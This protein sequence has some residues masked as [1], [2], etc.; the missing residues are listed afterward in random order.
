MSDQ[1]I[2]ENLEIRIKNTEQQICTLSLELA[3]LRK[4]RN[5]AHFPNPDNKCIDN[6][7][8]DTLNG[9]VFLQDL[10]GSRD[11]LLII[12]NMGQGCRYCTLWGDGLN[13]FLPH[14]ESTAAVAM[15]SGDSPSIQREFS[16]SR[17]WRFRMLSHNKGKY[18]QDQV[19][20][21]AFENRPGI[22]CYRKH[23]SGIYKVA[24]A[25]FGPG[26]QYCSLWHI[27]SL[28]GKTVQDWTPQYRYWS[29]PDNLE[30]GGA[31]IMD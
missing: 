16:N 20:T 17:Q 29:M 28:T 21:E 31:N 11:T 22:A 4:Q 26:D 6:Y 23:D 15:V 8:F 12:H 13:P 14:L 27:L 19:V 5:D 24:G 18:Y 7:Q 25:Q 9:Q 2:N 30:D 3:E 10:F 1:T